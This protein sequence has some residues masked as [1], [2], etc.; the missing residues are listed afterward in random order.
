M[1]TKLR[2]ALLSSLVA[3]P[4]FAAPFLAIGEN[5]EL[6]LTART[7]ARH[8]DN[9][10]LDN[11]NESADE[12]FE[13]VPGAELVFGKNSL[14]RGTLSFSERFISYSDRTKLNEELANVFFNSSYDGAKLSLDANASYRELF[15]NSRD[16]FAV[17]TLVRRD[18]LGAGLNAELTVTEKS[19]VGAGVQY[20]ETD[21]VTAGYADRETYTIPVNYYFAIRPKIDLSA[22]VQ[23]RSTDVSAGSDSEDLYFNVGARG[24]FTPKLVGNFRVGYTMRDWD[25][26]TLGED[27]MI[28]LDAGLT[29]L[30]SEKTQLTLNLSNDFGTASTGGGE[31]I[32]EISFGVRTQLTTDWSANAKIGYQDIDYVAVNRNDDFITGSLGVTYTLNQ[33]VSFDAN[34]SYADNSN[35]LAGGFAEFTANVFS[36]AANFRY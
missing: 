23:Y 22:G 31:E 16:I 1:T 5:A 32:A 17:G 2:L 33:Y 34:Y 30:Y 15:Q 19:K 21:Y 29:Y 24:E 26:G 13:F 4:A 35:N 9:V 12:I 20:A 10:F 18:Q 11:A 36:V 25:D 8:E 7:E 6:F 28:G 3:T 27:E 14:T